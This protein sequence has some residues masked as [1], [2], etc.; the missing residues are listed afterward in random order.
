MPWEQWRQTK[1][2]SEPQVLVCSGT[3]PFAT[4]KPMHAESYRM[5]SRMLQNHKPLT[6]TRIPESRPRSQSR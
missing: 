1:S 2:A 5:A 4:C 3:A 6:G